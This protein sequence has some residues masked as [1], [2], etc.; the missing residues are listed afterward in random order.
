MGFG[1][2]RFYS[3][4]FRCV[5]CK[6]GTG[7][8]SMSVRFWLLCLTQ[9]FFFPSFFFPPPANSLIFSLLIRPFC[10]FLTVL[11]ST[12]LL[13]VQ[14]PFPCAPCCD[15]STTDQED[16]QLENNTT[17]GGDYS[18]PSDVTQIRVSHQ[19]KPS[20]SLEAKIDWFMGKSATI[21]FFSLSPQ[22]CIFFPLMLLL[23]I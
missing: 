21:D 10:A 8:V 15:M 18:L 4:K 7:S 11:S 16:N 17:A 23:C 22:I 6:G 1:G 12:S 2:E 19:T 5:G 3:Q 13:P 20:F 9:Q 14:L